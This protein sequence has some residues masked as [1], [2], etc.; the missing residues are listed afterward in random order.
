MISPFRKSALLIL[1]II[2]AGET[3]LSA[4]SFSLFAVNDLLRVFSGKN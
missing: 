4:Q 3:G 1:S 2:L